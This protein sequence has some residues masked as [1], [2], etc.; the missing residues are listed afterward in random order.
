MWVKAEPSGLQR[1]EDSDSLSLSCWG[2]RQ[3]T[4]LSCVP[5]TSYSGLKRGT[6]PKAMLLLGEQTESHDLSVEGTNIWL[7]CSVWPWRAIPASEPPNSSLSTGSFEE[8]Q[9]TSSCVQFCFLNSLPPPKFSMLRAFS[10]KLLHAKAVSFSFWETDLWHTEIYI[11]L[12]FAQ[13]LKVCGH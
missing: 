9:K 8:L 7:P 13:I 11:N 12:V 10:N 4:T 6:L 5:L 2:S 1:L 3:V